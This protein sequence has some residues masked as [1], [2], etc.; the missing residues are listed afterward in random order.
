PPLPVG[1]NERSVARDAGSWALEAIRDVLE[2]VVVAG[3]V[4]P[5]LPV[6]GIGAVPTP[7]LDGELDGPGQLGIGV[8]QAI[9]VGV[10][11]VPPRLRVHRQRDLRAGGC[12]SRTHQDSHRHGDG[13]EYAEPGT[14]AWPHAAKVAPEQTS[15]NAG[16]FVRPATAAGPLVQRF[17]ALS[18]MRTRTHI[19]RFRSDSREF[20]R[21]YAA[22]WYLALL[23]DRWLAAPVQN[24][25]LNVEGRRGVLGP[26][27]R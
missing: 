15:V 14:P 26:A 24:F 4:A 7:A 13:Y 3:V 19:Q 22:A 11:R 21:R 18:P 5:E 1:R 23:T 10:D 6:V 8:V 20:G 25:L 2:V 12:R 9:D 16:S 27:H 17:P